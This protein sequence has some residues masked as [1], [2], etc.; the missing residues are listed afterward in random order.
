VGRVQR[1][2]QQRRHEAAMSC[3]GLVGKAQQTAAAAAAT[4]SRSACGD[5]RHG[6]PGA[7]VEQQGGAGAA[8]SGSSGGLQ[9]R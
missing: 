9:Q 6:Q 3:Q 1:Q 8:D 2:R 5:G 7:N 4:G